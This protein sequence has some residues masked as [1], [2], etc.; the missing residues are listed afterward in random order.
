MW[1]Q[2]QL[3]S[4]IEVY[5]VVSCYSCSWCLFP[6]PLQHIVFC[7]FCPF[8]VSCCSSPQF[9]LAFGYFRSLYRLCFSFHIPHPLFPL[10]FALLLLCPLFPLC[11]FPFQP[12]VSVCQS[13]LLNPLCSFLCYFLCF[14]FR[15]FYSCLI[16]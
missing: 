12:L 3:S 8:F 1:L 10:R 11:I 6:N 7:S 14:C 15:V 16:Y 2:A 4:S 9:L 5:K 13:S